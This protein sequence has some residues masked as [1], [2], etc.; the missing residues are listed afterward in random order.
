[1][2]AAALRKK[3]VVTPDLTIFFFMRMECYSEKRALA[4]DINRA[5]SEL[6]AVTHL[7]EKALARLVI[8]FKKRIMGNGARTPSIIW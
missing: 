8:L 1:M 4:R 5:G 2:L 7:E 6:V 3:D